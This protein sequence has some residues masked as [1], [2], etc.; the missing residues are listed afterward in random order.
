MSRV[1]KNPIPVPKGVTIVIASQDVTVKGNKGSLH[2]RLPALV[3]LVE[4]ENVIRVTPR[5]ETKDSDA[6]AGTTR[7]VISNM[8]NGVSNG[9]E[10]KLE[11]LG[12]GY[13]AQVQGK[14]LNLTL[15]FSH[16]VVYDIPEG[17]TIETPT[18]TEIVVKGLDKQLVGQVAAKIRSYREPEV[19]KGK[20]VRYSGEKIK[21]KEVKKK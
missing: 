11:L 21:L 9:F 2:Y 7:A 5:N 19:Y 12:V 8:V 17:I 20:G 10:R 14:K 3:M 4:E 16:P 18:Q 15:G 6:Q 13:R 1:A